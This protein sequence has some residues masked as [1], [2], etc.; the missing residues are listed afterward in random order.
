MYGTSDCHF[1]LHILLKVNDIVAGY[2]RILRFAFNVDD[3]VLGHLEAGQDG[4]SDGDAHP[5]F[6]LK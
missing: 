5:N 1:N 6:A 2:G 4:E 3:L